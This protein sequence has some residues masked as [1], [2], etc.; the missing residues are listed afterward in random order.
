MTASTPPPA[1][2]AIVPA[3]VDALLATVRDLLHS[4][5]NREQSLLSRASGLAAFAGLLLSLAG[6]ASAAVFSTHLERQLRAQGIP[7]A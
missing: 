4:E 3:T 6:A 1:L 2:P 5:D 7:L